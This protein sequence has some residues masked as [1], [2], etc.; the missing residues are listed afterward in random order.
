M[1]MLYS[2]AVIYLLLQVVASQSCPSGV[3]MKLPDDTD[4]LA[5]FYVDGSATQV[6]PPP[7]IFTCLCIH[8]V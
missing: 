4:L 5:E 1:N 3:D 8:F 2:L 6:L 7:G